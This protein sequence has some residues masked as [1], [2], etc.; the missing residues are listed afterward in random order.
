M[1]TINVRVTHHKAD[2]P[3]LEAVTFTDPMAAMRAVVALP[4]VKECVIVQTCNR[5]EIFAAAEDLDAAY[6]D[7]IDFFMDETISKMKKH[8]AG[9]MS[10][11]GIVQHMISSSKKLHD[12]IEAEFHAAAL[13]H[14]LRLTS[15]LE[16]MMIGEDQILGQVREAYHLAKAT[17]TVG[18]FFENIFTKALN[19]GKRARSETDISKGAVS[20]GSAAVELARSVFGSL[21]GKRALLIGA[22]E[23]GTLVAKSLCEL[24]LDSVK[25][26]NR[27]YE[28]GEK[29]AEEL[30]GTAIS[31]GDIAGA[32]AESDLVIAATGAPEAIITKAM[33]SEALNGRRRDV[34]IIDVAI[35]RDVEEGV[36]ELKGVRLFNIDGLREVAEKNRRARELEAVKVEAIVEAELSLLVKQ[37]YRIDIED[38]VKAVFGKAEHIRTKELEKAVRM[39][40]NG[41]GEKELRV[42]D[43]LTRVIITRTMTPI[44]DNIRKAAE[45]GDEPTIK[46]AEKWFLRELK[47]RPKG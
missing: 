44:A 38:I 5:V 36:G 28:K 30:G 21:E 16:S 35:P 42:I 24:K 15:G 23:M 12:V 27:T 3:T 11:E 32:L 14:L 43:D 10:S 45:T 17:N 25:V 34:V 1:H 2:I 41:M 37:I 47:H 22:G 26:V 9:S 19:V 13:H 40:G 7:I 33:M 6:H 4:T 31:F 18:P 8:F 20:I 39:L 46:V 29:L